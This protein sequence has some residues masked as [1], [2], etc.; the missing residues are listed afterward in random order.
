MLL[1]WMLWIWLLRAFL[2]R[3]SRY[4][5]VKVSEKHACLKEA[6]IRL[7]E[8]L[9]DQDEYVVQAANVSQP[10]KYAV[11]LPSCRFN[12]VSRSE[13]SICKGI[14]T[15]RIFNQIV[16]KAII[17]RFFWAYSKEVFSFLLAILEPGSL[18]LDWVHIDFN[19]LP[20]TQLIFGLV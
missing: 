17:S 2:L 8:Q 3:L 19:L 13:V 11:G 1:L 10:I 20:L 14:S 16:I 6:L 7:E 5:T 4:V 15:L 18:I 12:C 9:N